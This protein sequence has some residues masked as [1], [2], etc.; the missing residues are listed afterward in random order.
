MPRRH[1]YKDPGLAT[2]N[3]RE[4]CA[5]GRDRRPE[6][7]STCRVLCPRCGGVMTARCGR[8]GPYFHCLCYEHPGK[9]AGER[10]G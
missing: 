1:V 5:N 2:P 3:G 7:V 4:P 10:G 6:P 9:R 8:A